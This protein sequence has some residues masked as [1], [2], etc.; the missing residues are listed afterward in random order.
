MEWMRYGMRHGMIQWMRYGVRHE[1]RHGMR[2]GMRYRMIPKMWHR[3][4][5]YINE[6]LINLTL[7]SVV[8]WVQ[9][10]SLTQTCYFWAERLCD[11]VG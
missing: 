10:M 5:G 11:V 6:K 2:H 9:W 7:L 1:M 4:V 3:I 8:E